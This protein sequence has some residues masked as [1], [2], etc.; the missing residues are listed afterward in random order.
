MN[1][2]NLGKLEDL[3][4]LYYYTCVSGKKRKE[5]MIKKE[6]ILTRMTLQEKCNELH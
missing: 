5:F 1:E 6:L 4:R 2:S 3:L